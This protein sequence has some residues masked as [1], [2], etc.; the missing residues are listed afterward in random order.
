VVSGESDD[1]CWSA[2]LRVVARDPGT[3]FLQGDDGITRAEFAESRPSPDHGT[4]LRPGVDNGVQERVE[5]GERSQEL[6]LE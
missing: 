2:R 5:T 6:R 4:L 3:D 1:H